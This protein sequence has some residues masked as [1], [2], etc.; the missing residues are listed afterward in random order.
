MAHLKEFDKPLTT[1]ILSNPYHKVTKHILYL[2]S[3]ESF[4]YEDLNHASR[5]KDQ[6]K[7]K[8]YGAFS[9][10]L[11]YIIYNAN[12]KR[13]TNKLEGH[14]T[15]YRGLSLKQK[16]ADGFVPGSRIHLIGYTS[17]SKHFRCALKFAQKGIT[18]E[19]IPVVFQIHFKGSTGLFELTDE[20]T[21]YPGE[22]EVLVQDG[23]EY[24]V[25]QNEDQLT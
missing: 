10:A 12:K 22:D 5:E 13:T 14:N 6:T 18:D 16:E 4:I 1:S 17:T 11:S 24:L 7:I 20:F 15:L 23:L 8:Y 21:A 3:L 25:I 2:Y 9:A 19:K